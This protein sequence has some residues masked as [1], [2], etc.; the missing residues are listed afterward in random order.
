MNFFLRKY[1]IITII[2]A[3][4]VIIWIKLFYLQLINEDLKLASQD[5]SRRRITL[6]PSRG[7]IVDRNEEILASNITTY[8]LMLIPKYVKNLDSAVLICDYINMSNTE[9]A[10][11]FE[12]CKNYSKN[13][14]S[15]FYKLLTQEQYFVLREQLYRFPGFVFRKRTMRSYNVEISGH[16]LGDVGEISLEELKNNPYYIGGEYIGKNGIEKYY[17]KELCG[18]KGVEY[19]LIDVNNNKVGKYLNGDFDTAAQAG[20]KL[21]LTI[22][23]EFQRYCESIMK[24]KIGSIVAID[25]SNGEI[26]SLV[27]SP[28]F[29]PQDLVGRQR[30]KNYDNLM[31][32]KNNALHNRAVASEYPPG[33]IFKIAQTLVALDEG[34][35]GKNTYFPCD[36]SLVGC[37]NHPPCTDVSQAIQY[38]CNPY[39][40]Q[41]FKK[42]IL[43][44]KTGNVFIDSPVGLDAWNTKIKTLGF[45]QQ[46]E[47]G[48][49]YVKSGKVPNS[50]IYNQKYGKKRWAFS[51]IYSLSIGQGEVLAT[52]LQIANFCAIIA[53]K[54]FYYTPHLV[55]EINGEELPM[56][57]QKISTPFKEEYFDPII[58][59]M[60]MVVNEDFGTGCAA[61]IKNIIVCGK[62]GTAQNSKKDH[63][64]FM[65]FAPK[66]NPKIAVCVYVENAGWGNSWAAPIS[67]LVIEKYL[68]QE[69]S[70]TIFEKHIINS[71]LLP[72]NK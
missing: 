37:H 4:L 14:A 28:N 11:Q 66:D 62:T 15:L 6:F 49:P 64:V 16:I 63:S 50:E 10:E 45:G 38:S 25:P 46:L 53:N 42:I 51:T 54:G 32:D 72:Q 1:F 18:I 48:L 5:N 8:D 22:A 9:F 21:K 36:R 2:V 47:I 59:G 23:V 41:V 3:I 70:D 56:Y 39:F 68:K 52:P 31:K 7:M 12:K 40:Y 55:K 34:V 33:S 27:S 58:K 29:N 17:E 43:N 20:K 26:L 60:Y 71:S 69:V 44:K 19:I 65:A 61:K 57:K 30:S 13:K 24:N 67:H 35:I